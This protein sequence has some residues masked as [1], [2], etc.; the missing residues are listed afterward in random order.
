VGPRGH[1]EVDD[2]VVARVARAV[3]GGMGLLALHSAH[4]SKIFTR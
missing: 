4:Y 1:D 3:L 2:A